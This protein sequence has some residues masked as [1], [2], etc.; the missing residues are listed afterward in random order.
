MTV[1]DVRAWAD[2][3]GCEW[4]PGMPR[5]IDP[6]ARARRQ[7]ADDE[8]RRVG[9]FARTYAPITDNVARMAIE[10]FARF[11]EWP[12]TIRLI[13]KDRPLPARLVADANAARLAGPRP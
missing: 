8:L 7:A 4:E 2:A 1:E 10:Y 13:F 3:H 5:P 9:W 11:G 6:R 12:E